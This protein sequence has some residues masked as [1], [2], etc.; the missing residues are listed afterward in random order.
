MRTYPTPKDRDVTAPNADTL[1]SIAWIDL[2][3]EPY[4]LSIPDAGD[5]YYLMPMLD[6][7]TNVFQ[8]PGSRTTG[9]KAQRFAITGPSW[10]GQLPAG[11][12]EYK[13][14]TN[15]VW[16]L[17][18]TYCSGTPADYAAVHAFQDKLSL[19][20]LSA[21]GKPYTP[22][23]GRVDPTIDM[24]TPVRDQ[25]DRMNGTTFFGTLSAFFKNNPPTSADRPLIDKLARIGLVP[26]GDFEP[27][28]LHPVVMRALNAAP[29]A[30]QEAIKAQAK[31]AGHDVN[32]WLFSTKTG[33]YGTDYLQRA[34]ITAV[35]LG[36]NRPED[37]IYPMSE[38]D[39]DKKPYDGANEYVIHFPSGQTPPV[40]GF[41][42]VTMY[43]PS[44]FFVENP[45]HRYSISPRTLKPNADGSVDIYVQ[46]DSPGADRESNWLP[47]PAGK[48]NLMMRLYWP[49]QPI[50]AGTW[51]PPPVRVASNP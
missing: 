37:A 41:W 17:G 51:Q 27:S 18:R 2:A 50:L 39:A 30:G 31:K 12:T 49:E 43:D 35:G 23:P 6:G 48:F 20:P 10:H 38:T 44:F 22:P 5:R 11:V 32:G 47:A 36:A 33:T 26:G 4:V 15:L 40:K 29:A 45:I 42:S 9:T 24:K 46:K 34:F 7:Y 1:Y 14:P 16:I 28:K 25:V 19:V 8:D 21:L 3:K 13:S